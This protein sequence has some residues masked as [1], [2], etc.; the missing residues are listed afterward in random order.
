MRDLA[1]DVDPVGA[2]I[3]S[4][5]GASSASDARPRGIA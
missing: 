3:A 2:D 5:A 4:A 1:V